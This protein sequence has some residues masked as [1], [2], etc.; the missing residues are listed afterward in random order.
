MRALSLNPIICS[1]TFG[2]VWQAR[3]AFMMNCCICFVNLAELYEMSARTYTFVILIVKIPFCL[4]L[5][6]PAP[7]KKFCAE[8]LPPPFG[9]KR[10]EPRNGF[11]PN[12]GK[13]A[14]I[15]CRR[16]SKNHDETALNIQA[17]WHF[18]RKIAKSDLCLM[19]RVGRKSGVFPFSPRFPDFVSGRIWYTER[20][21]AKPRLCGY[22]KSRGDIDKPLNVQGLGGTTP[23]AIVGDKGR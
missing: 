9:A 3:F 13:R 14:A 12:R 7:E 11:Y 17:K 22:A 1:W 19:S 21:Y 8:L 10:E 15:D 5:V 18:L 6:P 16:F 23:L 4:A 2:S 20:V